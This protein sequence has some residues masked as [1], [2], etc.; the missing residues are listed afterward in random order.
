MSYKKQLPDKR[1]FVE[2]I[3]HYHCS[4]CHVYHPYEDMIKKTD[5]VYGVTRNCRKCY[6]ETYYMYKPKKNSERIHKPRRTQE[7]KLE[8]DKIHKEMRHIHFR[9]CGFEDLEEVKNVMNRLGYHD[10]E[11]VWVQFNRRHGF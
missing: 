3:P 11:P 6:L 10:R 7:Q 4:I 1:I 9:G 5:G 8:D 2:G